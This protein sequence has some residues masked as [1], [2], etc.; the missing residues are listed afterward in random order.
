MY[1][2]AATR[3]RG[4]HVHAGAIPQAMGKDQVG[5][6]GVAIAGHGNG[7]PP[8][9]R[10][11][12]PHRLGNI[13]R[14]QCFVVTANFPQSSQCHR[15]TSPGGGRFGQLENLRSRLLIAGCLPSCVGFVWPV[16]V[17]RLCRDTQGITGK[18]N[19]GCL[20]LF[21]LRTWQP[22]SQ[23]M[24]AVRQRLFSQLKPGDF[25]P[26]AEF[27]Q[28]GCQFLWFHARPRAVINP[29]VKWR[30]HKLIA[31]A[32]PDLAWRNVWCH[33][34][35]KLVLNQH[36]FSRDAAIHFVGRN[37][38]LEPL[39]TGENVGPSPSFQFW[40]DINTR[41]VLSF[42]PSVARALRQ[43]SYPTQGKELN[44]RSEPGRTDPDPFGNCV[45]EFQGWL[46]FSL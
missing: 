13:R 33:R 36:T 29:P 21:I 11:N 42:D 38:D 25:T 1:V 5:T 27:H 17:K 30:P 23:R 39:A 8:G 34:R 24:G 22:K 37:A 6:Q 43:G 20:I 14:R 16:R 35:G 3:L 40:G 9:L 2:E 44:Q 19:A 46:E 45:P 10:R 41:R 26:F 4:R 15:R 18:K 32:R 12:I 28:I 31:D 7:R